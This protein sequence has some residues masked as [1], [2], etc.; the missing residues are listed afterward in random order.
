MDSLVPQ[1]VL[2]ELSQILSNLVLGEN[3]IRKSA[4]KELNE[5]WLAN[6]PEAV[7]LALT[8]FTR[9]SPDDHMRSFAAVLLR[10]LMFRSVSSTSRLNPYTAI[11]DHLSENTRKTIE[12]LLLICLAN[13]GVESVRNKIVDTITEMAEGSMSRAR[14]SSDPSSPGGFFVLNYYEL[15]R[16]MAGAARFMIHLLAP[17]ND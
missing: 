3:E 1:A 5:K 12:A 10:R 15:I 7:L 16:S 2:F 9:Q 13:E 8:Q 11:Y 14:Q 17:I 6:Q 4:E